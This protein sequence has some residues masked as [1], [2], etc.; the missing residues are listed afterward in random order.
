MSTTARASSLNNRRGQDRAFTPDQ[1]LLP[2]LIRGDGAATGRTDGE[3]LIVRVGIEHLLLRLDDRKVLLERTA[4]PE[5]TA[6][7]IEIPDL[8]GNRSVLQNLR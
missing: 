3:Q 8:G 2:A 6:S 4:M 5:T 7:K 1:A